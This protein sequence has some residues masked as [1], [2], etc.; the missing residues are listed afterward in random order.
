MLT[1]LVI[2]SAINDL[3]LSSSALI[4]STPAYPDNTRHL[5]DNHER[6]I[7]TGWSWKKV[8]ESVCPLSLTDHYD[9]FTIKMSTAAAIAVWYNNTVGNKMIVHSVVKVHPTPN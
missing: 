5:A 7:M 3:D 8:G 1:P 4:L 6:E 2:L 9:F